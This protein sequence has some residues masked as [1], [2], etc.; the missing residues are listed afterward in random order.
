MGN[1][2]AGGQIGFDYDETSPPPSMPPIEHR[3]PTR[4][5]EEPKTYETAEQARVARAMK[6]LTGSEQ[7]TNPYIDKF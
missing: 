4:E 5:Q 3:R 1:P 7:G 2:E 6:R